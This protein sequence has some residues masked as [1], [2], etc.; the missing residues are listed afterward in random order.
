MKLENLDVMFKGDIVKKGETYLLV[1]ETRFINF[2]GI[3][4]SDGVEKHYLYGDIEVIAIG[5]RGFKEQ[6]KRYREA[7][8]E[9]EKTYDEYREVYEPGYI[10]G[11]VDGLDIAMGIFDKALEGEE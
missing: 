1:T 3:D 2:S 10:E 7:R 11:V 8:S 4:L 5:E 6:N 9:L